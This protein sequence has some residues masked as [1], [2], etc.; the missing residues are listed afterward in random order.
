MIYPSPIA[1]STSISVDSNV[2][3][4]ILG[5]AIL[6]QQMNMEGEQRQG[7]NLPVFSNDR[8]ES[9]HSFWILETDDNSQANHLKWEWWDSNRLG[10]TQPAVPEY[11]ICRTSNRNWSE[12]GDRLISWKE[13]RFR[14]VWT[15]G[16]ALICSWLPKI[17]IHLGFG[18]WHSTRD[19]G[20]V[21][22]MPT[23]R[24]ST[25]RRS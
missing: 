6:I 2:N 11:Q 5:N 3:F 21:N 4:C 23:V 17:K 16:V 7:S 1:P 25:S 20:V 12:P 22:N 14:V 10:S 24:A 8:M 18:N 13:I 9:L 19:C 15:A